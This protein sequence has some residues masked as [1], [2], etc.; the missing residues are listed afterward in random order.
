MLVRFRFC[1]N[2]AVG[3][4]GF[5]A[6]PSCFLRAGDE[7]LMYFEGRNE[8]F[9]FPCFFECLG[10]DACYGRGAFF[11]SVLEFLLFLVNVV[12]YDFMW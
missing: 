4:V 6:F 1:D 7:Y 8:G 5:S 12:C 2:E 3:S 10:V 9:V 11:G